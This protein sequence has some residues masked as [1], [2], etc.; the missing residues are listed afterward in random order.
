MLS[1]IDWLQSLIVKVLIK[2]ISLYVIR[3]ILE[4]NQVKNPLPLGMGVSDATT[5]CGQDYSI[6]GY[7]IPISDI[8]GN[9][10]VNE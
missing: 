5:L 10:Y 2:L 8:S 3:D 6:Q 4:V 9:W 1:L 7:G